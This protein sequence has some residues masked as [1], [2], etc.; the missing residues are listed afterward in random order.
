[1]SAGQETLEW[2]LSLRDEFTEK[3]QRAGISLQDFEEKGRTG[4]ASLIGSFTELDSMF[5]LIDRGAG[6]LRQGYDKT[7]GKVLEL[8]QAIAANVA[9][10]DNQAK[11]L[12]ISVEKLQEWQF[13]ADISDVSLTAISTG[14]RTL[15]KNVEDFSRGTGEAKAVFQQLGIEMADLSDSSGSMLAV[16]MLFGKVA[17][18]LSMVENGSKRLAYAQKLLGESGTQLLPIILDGGKAFAALQEEARQAGYVIGHEQVAEYRAMRDE[19]SRL[20]TE[21][22]A[23]TRETIEPFVPLI[24]K[25]ASIVRTF[26]HGVRDLKEEFWGFSRAEQLKKQIQETRG[27]ISDLR[28]ELEAMAVLDLGAD[29]DDP[30][31]YQNFVRAM[32]SSPAAQALE[33]K[34]KDYQEILAV[35]QADLQMAQGIAS[36]ASPGAPVGSGQEGATEER[37]DARKA[38]LERLALENELAQADEFQQLEIHRQ[39]LLQQADGFGALEIEINQKYDR[40]SQE[41]LDKRI[42][43]SEKLA[44]KEAETEAKRAEQAAKELERETERINQIVERYATEEELLQ[45]HL[46][47]Q[48]EMVKAYQQS[49]LDDQSLTEDQRRELLAKAHDAQGA[50]EEKRAK[51]STTRHTKDAKEREKETVQ[52]ENNLL[53]IA[54]VFGGKHSEVAKS[55]QIARALRNVPMAISEALASGPPPWNFIAAAAVAAQAKQQVDSIRSDGGGSGLGGGIGFPSAAQGADTVPSIEPAV[56]DGAKGR[57]SVTVIAQGDILDLDG[58]VRT[59]V[60]PAFK[61]AVADGYDVG[62]LARSA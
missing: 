7:V 20:Q 30:G 52:R 29:E 15:N 35:F 18:R 46:E 17:E 33:Q 4:N 41:L 19:I 5:S 48:L 38:L 16:D 57:I 23:L 13:A 9:Q 21:W 62:V 31:G 43:E 51:A 26:V 53:T 1:V 37:V 11:A 49:L 28:N 32:E 42:E 36:A 39:R 60:V 10:L 54:T 44:S 6:M 14:L 25:A 27:V 45:I 3:L 22:D 56:A 8:A 58:F 34:I 55:L 2:L 47:E 12:D 61:D 59:K 50:L 24:E 40:L